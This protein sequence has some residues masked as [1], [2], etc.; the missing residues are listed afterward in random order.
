MADKDLTVL[1]PLADRRACRVESLLAMTG[2]SGAGGFA[3][4]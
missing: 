3:V 2:R 1:R 4:G